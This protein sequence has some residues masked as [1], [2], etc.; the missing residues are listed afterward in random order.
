MLEK[1]LGAVTLN[2]YG[3]TGAAADKSSHQPGGRVCV[4]VRD[5]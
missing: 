4:A 3:R 5:G 1:L 2:D